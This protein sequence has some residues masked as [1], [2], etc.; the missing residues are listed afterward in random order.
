MVSGLSVSFFRFV[1]MFFHFLQRGQGNKH[2]LKLRRFL[3][4]CSS[5]AFVHGDRRVIE[6]LLSHS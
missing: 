5:L 2:S 6:S 4:S 1:L 3:I